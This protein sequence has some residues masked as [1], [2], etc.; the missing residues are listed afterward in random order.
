MPWFSKLIP[1]N[2]ELSEAAIQTDGYTAIPLPELISGD[3]LLRISELLGTDRGELSCY[4]YGSQPNEKSIDFNDRGVDLFWNETH[5][6]TLLK[7]TEIDL[8]IWSPGEHDYFIIFGSHTLVQMIISSGIFSYSFKE[9]M[10]EDCFG[11]TKTAHLKTVRDR[12]S[13]NGTQ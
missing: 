1:L 6:Y 2:R 5:N 9:Y 10:N 13:I 12:Y 11:P 3:E 4:Q 8:F 7:F